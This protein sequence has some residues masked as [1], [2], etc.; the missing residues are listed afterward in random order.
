MA[1]PNQPNYGFTPGPEAPNPYAPQQQQTQG[2]GMA[3]AAL[4][5]GII[6]VV[7]CFIVVLNWILAL[8]AIIFGAVGISKANKIGGKG[9]GMATAGLVLGLVG[10]ILG[11]VI[12]AWAM[13]QI[14]KARRFDRYGTVTT[15]DTRTVA[16][17]TM[18]APDLV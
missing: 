10:A 6:A 7:L 17:L 18:P 12:V 11:V 3:V 1:D 5:L 2:N 13:H 14:S 4:V 15:P 8:L 16:E 9:K